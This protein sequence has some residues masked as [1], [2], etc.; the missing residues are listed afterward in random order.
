MQTLTIR[1][2]CFS[3]DATNL[4]SY[5]I[6]SVFNPF[7]IGVIGGDGVDSSIRFPNVFGRAGSVPDTGST[8]AM[9][10]ISLLGLGLGFNQ[11]SRDSTRLT[12]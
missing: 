12:G 3:V 6:G 4:D 2:I 10:S 11:L 8:V 5:G 7:Q 1:L 9:L